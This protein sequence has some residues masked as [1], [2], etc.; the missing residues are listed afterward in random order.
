ML[1][2]LHQRLIFDVLREFIKRERGCLPGRMCLGLEGGAEA[3]GGVG[4]LGRSSQQCVRGKDRGEQVWS[5]AT[6]DLAGKET[7]LVL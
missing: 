5:Q 3:V 1:N 7:P 4:L 2:R 6:E